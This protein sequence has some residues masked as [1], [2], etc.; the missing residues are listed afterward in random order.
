MSTISILPTP[1]ALLEAALRAR[2][3]VEVCYHG[4]RR[5]ICPHALGWNNGRAMVLGY[6]TGGETSTGTLPADRAERWRCMFVDEI[7]QVLAADSDSPW[8]SADNYN[9]SHPFASIDMLAIAVGIDGPDHAG[10]L[11]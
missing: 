7:E 8:Q 1:W 2:R 10:R 3:P 11:Q 5:V 4:R 9:S 6:Q